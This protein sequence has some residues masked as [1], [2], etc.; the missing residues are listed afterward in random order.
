MTSKLIHLCNDIC[1]QYSLYNGSKWPHNN[2]LNSSI[3]RALHNYCR[4]SSKS[5]EITYVQAFTYLC[6]KPLCVPFAAP[7]NSS[8]LWNGHQMKR[9]QLSTQ[10]MNH[11]FTTCLLSHFQNPEPSPQ[12]LLL[13][14]LSQ[15]LL[16]WPLQT[17]CASC[18]TLQSPCTGTNFQPSYHLLQ[19]H[20]QTPHC[21]RCLTHT[22]FSV[23]RGSQCRWAGQ[24]TCPFFTEWTFSDRKQTGFLYL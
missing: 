11:L 8:Y 4:Q 5:E 23:K 14:R 9:V 16:D 1:T 24:G 21:Q 15:S 19:D 17:S 2:T 22:S 3:L 20:S 10:L 7:P 18:R 6:S 12:F 13:T